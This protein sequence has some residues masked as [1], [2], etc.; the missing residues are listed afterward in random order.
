MAVPNSITL[1]FIT[2]VS[3]KR[4]RR[5]E[6]IWLGMFGSRQ[7]GTVLFHESFIHAERDMLNRYIAGGFLRQSTV[8]TELMKYKL[9]AEIPSKESDHSPDRKTGCP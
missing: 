6:D 1:R 9:G 3:E 8:G 4:T 2:T 7:S 5:E